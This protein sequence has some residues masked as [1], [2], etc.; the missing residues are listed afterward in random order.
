MAEEGRRQ[1][2]WIRIPLPNDSVILANACGD[3]WRWIQTDE[4][5]GKWE[6]DRAM[7]GE[8]LISIFFSDPNTAFEFKIRFG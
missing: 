7:E 3:G 2:N 1:P 6:L 8:F 4:A 5:K